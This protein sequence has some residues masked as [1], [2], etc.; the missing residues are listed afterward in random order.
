[1]RLLQLGV[2]DQEKIE[3]L[4]QKAATL[5]ANAAD[6]N[7]VREYHACMKILLA[8]AKLEQDERKLA[9]LGRIPPSQHA[10]AHLHLIADASTLSAIAAEIGIADLFETGG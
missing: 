4:I 10:H 1:M 6:N 8:A 3:D 2:I 7:K 9:Q 5:A